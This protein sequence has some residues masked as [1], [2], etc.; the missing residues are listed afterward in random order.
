MDKARILYNHLYWNEGLQRSDV[1]SLSGDEHYLKIVDHPNYNPRL[2]E[3]AVSD[4]S[5]ARR[6]QR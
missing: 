4:L 1:E 3:A 5:F 6:R 2:I